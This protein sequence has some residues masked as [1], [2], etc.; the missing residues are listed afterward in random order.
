MSILILCTLKHHVF[1]FLSLARAI[2][3]ND[4]QSSLTGHESITDGKCHI[5]M[6]DQISLHV[7]GTQIYI[8]I[9]TLKLFII[10][11]R[12]WLFF[13]RG[14]DVHVLTFY[15]F[16]ICL[17][18]CLS[19]CLSV[20][21]ADCLCQVCS[22]W[23]NPVDLLFQVL[24]FLLGKPQRMERRYPTVSGTLLGRLSITILTM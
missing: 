3:S 22:F 13:T 24:T 15:A 11:S 16:P 4:L 18:V 2:Q 23:L 19:I 12:I 5:V 21:L 9:Y 6:S 10:F 14:F 7:P 8:Y 17:S 1:V 20:C